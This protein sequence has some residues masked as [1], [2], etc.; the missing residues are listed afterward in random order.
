[1][2]NFV[3]KAATL[4]T[5]A[6]AVLM[7][8]APAATAVQAQSPITVTWFVGL[9]TGT[10]AA[11]KDAQQAVVDAF[12]KS[13]SAIVLKINIA[14][15]N[16][17]APDILS[18]LIASGNAP[19]IVGPVGFTGANSFEGNWLDLTSEIAKNKYDLSKFPDSLLSIYKSPAEGMTAIPFAVYPGMLFYNKDLFDAAGLAYPPSKVGDKYTLNG[20]QVD[21]TYDTVAQVAKLLT[22]DSAGNDATSAKF[23]PTKIA[24]Y[25]FV[26]QYGTI[27][28]EF[29]TFGGAPVVDATSGKVKITDAWRAE[30]TWI[31]NG[32]WKDHFIPSASAASS[33]LLAPS[34]FA[35]GK[36]A[37]ARTM[38]WYT[39]CVS[40]LKG[41]WDLGVQPSYNGTTYAPA[42]ADSLRIMKATK[43][44][45]AAF[46]VMEYLLGDGAAPLLT[47]YGAYPARP[48]LQKAVLAA[49]AAKFPSVTHW[50]I[51]PDQ[52]AYAVAPHHESFY[53]G[54][55][56]GQDRFQQF[57]TLLYGDTGASID[58]N[59]ELDKL[60]S[61]LQAIV[62]AASSP[63]AAATAAATA[64]K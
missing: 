44:P 18:T 33:T 15:T 54:F 14:A 28:S 35:S 6:A 30:A 13:Q 38:F 8:V 56:K 3:R 21:W 2:N 26:H 25:G 55:N 7:A 61:D 36:T 24:Q 43:N 62:D 50:D 52:M 46:T 48:D 1:M 60:Q 51:V 12:N 59:K 32:L 41:K 49:D 4:V 20:K 40:A 63:A 17:T 29:E 37:M 11:Q 45:D 57:R 34:E 58:I 19:D 31:Y 39:C 23:D 10:D 27:R 47:A 64:A 42:D 9:G 16:Q 22:I 5:A 53:P